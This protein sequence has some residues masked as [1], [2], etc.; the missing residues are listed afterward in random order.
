MHEGHV[1]GNGSRELEG[2]VDRCDVLIIVTELNSRRNAREANGAS[3]RVQ[4]ASGSK[5]Q[6][7]DAAES[8]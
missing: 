3:S 7:H 5:G 4:V 2:L 6:R 8:H 1:G